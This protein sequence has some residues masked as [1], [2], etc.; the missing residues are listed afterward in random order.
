M[1][2]LAQITNTSIFAFM[3]VLCFQLLSRKVLFLNRKDNRNYQ[4]A[5]WFFKKIANF[6]GKL[7]QDY[8]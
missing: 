5:D 7:L 1:I 8:K 3:A 2:A 6:T 4:K